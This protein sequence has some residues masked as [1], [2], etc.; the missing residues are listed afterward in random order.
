VLLPRC[1]AGR[2]VA[3]QSRGARILH[4]A[5][6]GRHQLLHSRLSHADQQQLALLSRLGGRTGWAPDM[7]R[8]HR[9]R[10]APHAQRGE[11]TLLRAAHRSYWKVLSG[12]AGLQRQQRAH[13]AVVWLLGAQRRLKIY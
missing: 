8:P 4:A 6:A 2:C 9:P 10:T 5:A 12:S 3:T 13:T 1:V 7:S 11:T